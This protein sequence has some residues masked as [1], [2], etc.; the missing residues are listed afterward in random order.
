[1]S[2]KSSA[3]TPATAVYACKS[4]L[5][6][7]DLWV[8]VCFKVATLTL[9]QYPLPLWSACTW[10]LTLAMRRP[11]TLLALSTPALRNL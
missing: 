2:A 1:M 8:W 5:A 6:H 3:R 7:L 10:T 9:H 11:G 4:F